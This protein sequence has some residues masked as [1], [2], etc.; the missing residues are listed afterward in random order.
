MSVCAHDPRC[1]GYPTNPRCPERRP[2]SRTPLVCKVPKCKRS[3]RADEVTCDK[4]EDIEIHEFVKPKPTT[5]L[6]Y[7]MLLYAAGY[8]T[9][10]EIA[11]QNRSKARARTRVARKSRKRNR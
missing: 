3:A 1:P 9:P 4:H 5:R 8:K 10:K 6:G 2:T 11:Q 7:S